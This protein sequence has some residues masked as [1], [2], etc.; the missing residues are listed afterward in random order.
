MADTV[1]VQGLRELQ[2]AFAR[3]GGEVQ[4]EI[5]EGLVKAAEPVRGRAET[6]AVQEIRNIGS[7][8]SRMRIGVT[9]KLVYVAP[10]MRRRRGTPRPNLAPLLMNRAMQPALDESAPEVVAALDF[11]VDRL[12][13]ENGF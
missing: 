3:I 1:R 10:A 5:R 7:A 2:S 13:G 8:W 4:G 6:H 11:V 9:T 12:A